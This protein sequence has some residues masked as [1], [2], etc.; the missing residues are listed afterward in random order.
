MTTIKK[1]P[2][3]LAAL[4]MLA[5]P[6]TFEVRPFI[7]DDV[8]LIGLKR[9]KLATWTFINNS[10]AEFWY[11]YTMNLT[12]RFEMQVTVHWGYCKLED[13]KRRKFSYI[14]PLL[15]SKFLL[16]EY[17]FKGIRR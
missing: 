2:L 4:T 13:N 8:T 10:E 1:I 16:H 5:I 11:N 9:A 17:I 6:H 3:T 14:A 12:W 7:T 15:Q